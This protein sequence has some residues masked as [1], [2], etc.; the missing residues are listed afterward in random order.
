MFPPQIKHHSLRRWLHDLG[1]KF[2]EFKKK[3]YF[4]GHEREDVVLDR[5][6]LNQE[7]QEAKK[8]TNKIIEISLEEIPVPG[9]THI[10]VTQDKKIHHS[11]DI[12]TRY[13]N[14]LVYTYHTYISWPA[15]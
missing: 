8:K 4:D 5:Q 2:T 10:R 6:Q 11:K 13:L 7:M 14:S 3:F 1:F 15:E 12:Q 9:S